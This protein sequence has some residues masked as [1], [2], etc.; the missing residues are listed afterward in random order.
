MIFIAL[1]FV[2]SKLDDPCRNGQPVG[3]SQRGGVQTGKT[4][5]TI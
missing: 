4:G 5:V 1:P 2:E 3:G